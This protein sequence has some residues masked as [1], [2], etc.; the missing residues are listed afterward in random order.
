MKVSLAMA[1]YNGEK[2]LIEQLDSIRNQTRR[3]DE[4]MIIDDCSTD[5]TVEK[6]NNFLKKYNLNNWKIVKNVENKGWKRNFMEG[7]WR[8][9]GDL[10][11]PCDQDDIW[12]PDKLQL[13]EAIMVE[14]PEINVLTSNY[15][16]FYDSGKTIIGPSKRKHE[17][18]KQDMVQNIFNT[19]YP[20][21]TYCVRRQIAELSKKYWQED[22]PHD[23]L[24]WRMA[25][26]SDS[27][28]TYSKC[29]IKWRKHE[30][31]AF[32]VE[33]VQSKTK[34]QKRKWIEYAKRVIES[35]ESFIENEN[36]DGTAKK[37]ILKTSDQWLNMRARF[38]DTK[39]IFYWFKLIR[40]M[41]CYDRFKQYLGDFYLV[42]IKNKND[43]I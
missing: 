4:V 9:N 15:E 14:H 25:M 38:Y 21:C 22:F 13:M 18:F 41:N 30:D 1:V 31:S 11:F 2:Y 34:M 36:I 3:A 40:Y 43:N 23:A 28:Y 29:L 20:G 35:L 10:I 8:S 17:L 26:F 33:S 12:M 39:N 27:L 32:T 6:I 24:L 7:I 19:P 5:D 37:D 42:L 16:A